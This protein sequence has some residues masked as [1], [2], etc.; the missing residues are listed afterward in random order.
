[1]DRLITEIRNKNCR[2]SSHKLCVIYSFSGLTALALQSVD[3]LQEVMS[4][5]VASGTCTTGMEIAREANNGHSG[6][7]FNCHIY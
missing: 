4:V 7:G 3:V 6:R 5:V 2:R 1:M